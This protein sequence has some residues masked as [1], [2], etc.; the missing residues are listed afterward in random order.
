MCNTQL[1]SS[2]TTAGSEDIDSLPAIQQ[3]LENLLAFA[4]ERA[5]VGPAHGI[6][7]ASIIDEINATISAAKTVDVDG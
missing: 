3:S 6:M 4:K 2:T 1:S 5:A 7:F